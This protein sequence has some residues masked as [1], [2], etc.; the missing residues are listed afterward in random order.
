MASKKDNNSIRKLATFQSILIVLVCVASLEVTSLIQYYYSNK[1]LAEEA[2]RRAEGQLEATELQITNIIDRV[3][4][5]VKNNIWSVEQQ[6]DKP[7]SLAA[8]TRRIVQTNPVICGSAIALIDR[9]LAPYTSKADGQTITGSLATEEYDYHS[10][11]WFTKPLEFGRGYWSEPYFDEGGGNIVM[12][13]F[14][15]PVT[16]KK[17]RLAAVLT[18][19]VSL[20]WLTELVGNIKVYPNA[21]SM[22]VSREGRIMVCPAE[23]LVMKKTIHEVA[24]SMDDA[25][26]FNSLNNSM[27]SGERGNIH[28]RYQ[29]KVLYMFFDSVQ[30]TGWGMSIVVPKDEI[31]S[32]VRRVGFMVLILQILAVALLILIIWATV[33]SQRRL[34]LVSEKKNRIEGELSVARDIQMSML[35]KVFPTV[36]DSKEVD[37]FATVIPAKEVGGDL[38]DFHIREDKL[39]F[40]IGDV[41]G[42]GVPAAL[43]MSVCR[44]LFRSLSSKEDS[45]ATIVTSINETISENNESEMFVTLFCGVLDLKNGNMRYCNAGHNYPVAMN[46]DGNSFMDVVPNLPLGIMQGFVFEE[47]SIK[48]R[49]GEGLFLYT[50]GLNEAENLEHAQ[51]GEE[52]MISAL[53]LK[54]DATSQVKIMTEFVSAFVGSAPQSDDLSMLCIHYINKA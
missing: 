4:T 14:S 40:C 44:S 10:K 11:E 26:S 13:T 36:P 9:D 48:L 3:E 47:Q 22:V 43:V 46:A 34:R 32:G 24:E 2:N 49:T 51:F 50:D 17:G 29:G 27:L 8:I 16:D 45:P 52:R 41:S 23:T 15:V 25:E 7:D 33:R 42:K 38:Y 19:D 35:P 20:D 30:R 18:A 6:L 28:F 31:F 12:T 5:A 1:V 21:F 39:F 53:N 37:L 54:L